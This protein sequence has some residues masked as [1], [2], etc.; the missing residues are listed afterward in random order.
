MSFKSFHSYIWLLPFL[1][2]LFGY[3]IMAKVYPIKQVKTPALIGKSIQEAVQELSD[4]NLN[5]RIIGSK[6]EIDLPHGT[7]ISQ[8]PAPENSI[9][10]Y[11]TIYCLISTKPDDPLIDNFVM[12][13]KHDV[14]QVL[15]QNKMRFKVLYVPSIYPKETCIGQFPKAGGTYKKNQTIILYISG[16]T[17]KPIVWPDFRNNSVESVKD[18]LSSAGIQYS[19]NHTRLVLENH[20]CSECMVIDQRP[21]P[22][23]ILMLNDSNSLFVKLQVR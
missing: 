13:T 8:N 3:V 14:I 15:Q 7:I 9:K 5:L 6:Q 21:L 17:S 11:Q 22:G 23:S 2:F 4:K 12:K 20:N 1:A 10:Q 19:I 16:D 18:F